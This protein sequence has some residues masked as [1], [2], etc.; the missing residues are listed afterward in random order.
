MEN[1]IKFIDRCFILLRII[2][3]WPIFGGQ[4]KKIINCDLQAYD[5]SNKSFICKLCVVLEKFK[6]FKNIVFFRLK[7]KHFCFAILFRLLFGFK[8]DLEISGDIG[9]GFAVFH[10][11]GSVVYLKRAG[12]NLHI[13]QGVTIGR[14]PKPTIKDDIPVLGDNVSVYTNAIVVGNIKIGNNVSISAGAFVN[15]DVPDNSYVFGNPG[16][17]YIKKINEK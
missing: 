2:F 14:N 13:W 1:V 3:I 10:G 17:I 8:K 4:T 9:P 7:K 12:K 11:H 16:K 6:C 15:F 5:D